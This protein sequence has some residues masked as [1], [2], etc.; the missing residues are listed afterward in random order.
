MHP[1]TP[2]HRWLYDWLLGLHHH[3]LAEACRQVARHHC[4][5]RSCVHQRMQQKLLQGLLRT[6]PTSASTAAQPTAPVDSKHKYALHKRPPS[7]H[8]PAQL[9]LSCKVPYFSYR[10]RE[11]AATSLPRHT[12]TDSRALIKGPAWA[13][14][15]K[16]SQNHTGLSSYWT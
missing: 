6:C 10:Y 9:L 12:S 3:Q 14:S 16:T 4:L 7:Q 5:W 13:R 15:T 8:L 1:D 2:A 11:P